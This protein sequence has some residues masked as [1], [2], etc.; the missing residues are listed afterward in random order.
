MRLRRITTEKI[1]ILYVT[2]ARI[3]GERAHSI[4]IARM[5]SALQEMG[6]DVILISPKRGDKLTRKAKMK[7]VM[8][9]YGLKIPFMHFKV[10]V[11]AIFNEYVKVENLSWF[12]MAWTL[13]SFTLALNMTLKFFLRKNVYIYVREPLL[14][15]TLTVGGW[16]MKPKII[17]EIHELPPPQK[18]SPRFFWSLM[19]RSP[20]IICIA[21][22]LSDLVRSRLDNGKERV[23]TLHDAVDDEIF[24]IEYSC[25]ED[26]ASIKKKYRIIMYTGHLDK[27]KRPEFLIDMMK[28]VV[29]R[30][31]ALVFVGGK[32]E[33]IS[34][35]RQY[36]AVNGLNGKV[37]FLGWR[38][39]AQVPRYL[40]FADVLVHYSP[41][42][43]ALS[44]LKIF[45]Y[46]LSGRP[47]AAPRAP[48]VEEVL[49]DGINALLFDPLD[50]ADAARKVMLLLRDKELSEMLASNA[51]NAVLSKYTYRA[52]ARTLL[53]LLKTLAVENNKKQ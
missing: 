39:P 28:Y 50:P 53:D 37:F 11:L 12:I 17:Y 14:F 43:K 16:L 6:S 8:E 33:D 7:D 13:A 4:Q 26:L 5:C 23:F 42:G 32:E 2:M 48:G 40:A 49:K 44:P 35:L 34:R 18:D 45:E 25:P 20:L 3:P 21:Q 36:V 29:E 30:D 1:T 41:P 38:A 46:M 22:A 15:I 24:K 9:Y 10:P 19:K 31:V 52:R 51:K 27:W 47:I